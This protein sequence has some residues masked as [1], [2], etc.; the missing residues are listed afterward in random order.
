MD[1]KLFQKKLPRIDQFNIKPY[2][3]NFSLSSL[4]TGV[5]N[6]RYDVLVSPGLK[7]AINTVVVQLMMKYTEVNDHLKMADPGRWIKEKDEFKRLC[8]E[9]L[10]N[11]IHQARSKQ[12]IPIDYLCQTALI[13]VI[14]KEITAVYDTMLDQFKQ[15]IRE[16][17]F[18]HSREAVL[19]YNKEL[20]RIQRDKDAI[21]LEIGKEIFSHLA[22]VHRNLKQM[23]ELNFGKS[24]VLPT[25]FITN[26]MIH[27]NDVS[28]DEFMLEEYDIL[29]GQRLDD[30]DKYDRLI[31]LINALFNK[32]DPVRNPGLDPE[33]QLLSNPGNPSE[34]SASIED[35]GK[36]CFCG[37]NSQ[38]DNGEL[39]RLRSWLSRIENVD[40]LFNYYQTE[41][42]YR[43]LKK[44]KGDR[45]EL[46][47]LKK[48]A[49]HQKLLLR[50]FLKEFKKNGLLERANATYEMIPVYHQYCPPLVPQ[51]VLQF[52][53]SRKIR[54]TVIAR[55]KKLQKFYSK[56]FNLYP[57]YRAMKNIKRMKKIAVEG[58]LIRF[59]SGFMR[60]HRDY[61]HYQIVKSAMDCINLPAEE[62]TINLSRANGSLYEFLLKHEQVVEE[63][64]IINH[65]IIKAD[66]RGSTDITHRMIERSLNPATYFSMNLFDPINELLPEYGASK[67]FVEG[68]A[69]ILSIFERENT[70]ERWYA[71]ARSC[72]LAANIL[73]I[74]Q[75]YNQRSR[76]NRLPIIELGIGICFQQGRP[77]FLFDGENRIMISSAINLSDRMSGCSKGIRKILENKKLPFNLYVYQTASDEEVRSTADDISVRYNVNG[78]QL[79]AE[80]FMKLQKEIDIKQV[81]IPKKAFQKEDFRI[82]TGKFPTNTGR[83]HR[84]VIRKARIPKVNPETLV[85]EKWTDQFYYEVCTNQKLYEYIKKI[86]GN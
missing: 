61:G 24:A 84:L 54:K 57:L 4:V 27:T 65:V 45:S 19:S 13:K 22:D 23:R 44:K 11:G 60:Y 18:A 85:H 29:L 58:N 49:R 10:L 14:L 39:R 70:P 74:V 67:V 76:E 78:I 33:N 81:K 77:A 52:I 82:Y 28:G 26:P 75:R 3:I 1:L 30:P 86:S 41:Y 69:I 9:V 31:I 72:G 34:K 59:L 20:S 63:R 62:K 40:I 21:I 15:M 71:V 80:G 66:V 79:S 68:D 2:A 37:F 83:Y 25:S 7:N 36:D 35:Q 51:L 6:I 50:Y 56:R 8:K 5:D 32:V 48:N 16:R 64:P 38:Q 46:R 53:I 12:Q 17:E 47:Q 73:F 43:L 55:L 42:Q